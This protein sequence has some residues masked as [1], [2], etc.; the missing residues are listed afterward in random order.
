[1]LFA[2]SRYLYLDFALTALV[3]LSIALLLAS[4]SALGGG[5]PAWALGWR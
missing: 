1:M 5:G 4:H 3:A 2:M